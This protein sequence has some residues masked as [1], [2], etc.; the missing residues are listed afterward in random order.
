MTNS[1]TA[2][3]ILNYIR[4][5]ASDEYKSRIP[6]AVQD[7][8]TAVGNA[9][10]EYTPTKNEF[11][12][13]LV[14]KIGLTIVSRIEYAN[15]FS[16]FKGEPIRYGDTIEDIYVDLV[17]AQAYNP[18]N[19]NP[20]PQKKPNINTLY[21]KVDREMQY[22][23]TINDDLLRRAFRSQDGVNNLVTSIIDSLYTSKSYDEYLM[24]KHLLSGD[25]YGKV[26]EIPTGTTKEIAQNTLS[27]IRSMIS[28]MSYMSTEYNKL[29]TNQNTSSNDVYLILRSD[30]R[31]SIDMD[32]LAG[33][34]NLDKVSLDAHIIEVDSF[35]DENHLFSLIDR[36]GMRIHDALDDAETIRNPEGKYTN[37]Y[38]NHW[39]LQSFSIYRNAIKGV[40]A[41][42]AGA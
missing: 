22:K 33:I 14:N 9:I 23:V 7:N 12:N 40:Q 8:I 31:L 17:E 30:I 21:H 24:T 18:N 29:N 38:V 4:A 39:A 42:S 27:I 25:I 6:Q 32:V 20:F 11:L 35:E 26:V 41:T 37:Y 19:E 1:Q 3:N 5:N 2:L 16:V 34:F 28:A 36:R 10:L 15:R 13:M